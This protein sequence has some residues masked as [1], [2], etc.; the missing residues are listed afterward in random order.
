MPQVPPSPA[1]GTSGSIGYGAATTTGG[2]I[3]A[4][5][6]CSST[7]AFPGSPSID[8]GDTAVYYVQFTFTLDVGAPDD[9]LMFG[10]D[11]GAAIQITG[12]SIS[13]A[14][15]YLFKIS[16]AGF[17]GELGETGV[18]GN[19]VSFPSYFADANYPIGSATATTLVAETVL[20]ANK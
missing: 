20:E 18:T 14:H 2:A 1:A 6:A 17:T 7:T 11:P 10:S 15:G 3:I 16:A 8:S 13:S 5:Q 9:V 4:V 19:T 12:P